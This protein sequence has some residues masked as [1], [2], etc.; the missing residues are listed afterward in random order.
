MLYGR[1]ELPRLCPRGI[2]LMVVRPNKSIGEPLARLI[3]VS[4]AIGLIALAVVIFWT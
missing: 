2:V 3:V 1:R 4:V